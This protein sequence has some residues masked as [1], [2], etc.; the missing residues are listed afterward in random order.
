MHRTPDVSRS[1]SRA[2]LA[3][4]ALAAVALG[5]AGS[6]D[7][8]AAAARDDVALLIRLDAAMQKAVVDIDTQAFAGFL[9][10]DYKLVVSSSRVVG[11][12]EVVAELREPDT[13]LTTN[14]SS[15]LDVRVHG[16]TAI[17]IADLHQ[18]GQVRGKPVDYWV[19][20]TDTWIRVG[21]S[22]RCVSGHATKLATP[23]T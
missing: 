6:P 9:T 20:Y 4:A 7:S 12:A 18:A 13:H 8:H 17:V 2:L 3:G 5:V 10:D 23:T 21:D 19:R 16:D 11:K 1:T 14:A 22:W 15:N